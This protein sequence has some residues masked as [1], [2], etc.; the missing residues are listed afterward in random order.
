MPWI[1][2]SMHEAALHRIASS[3]SVR[4]ANNLRHILRTCSYAVW[5]ESNSS[6]SIKVSIVF[7]A[8]SVFFAV[9]VP[10]RRTHVLVCVIKFTSLTVITHSFN[11]THIHVPALTQC[12]T[13]LPKHTQIHFFNS[14]FY[15]GSRRHTLTYTHFHIFTSTKTHK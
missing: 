10:R 9:S 13:Q 15:S 1:H 8:W 2:L 3:A 14:Y 12:H 6:R 5:L 7:C 4:S 11:Q